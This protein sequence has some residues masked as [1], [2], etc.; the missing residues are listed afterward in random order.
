[1]A[2]SAAV[3]PSS[4]AW[5]NKKMSRRVGSPN[6]AVIAVTVDANSV[7]VRSR[8][9]AGVE[10]AEPVGAELGETVFTPI[11]YLRR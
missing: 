11:F 2:V 5:A 7:G 6:A 3:T 9:L 8:R 4:L 10:A 1:M